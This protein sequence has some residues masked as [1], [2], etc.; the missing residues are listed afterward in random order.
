MTHRVG[1]KGQVVIPKAFRVALGL[2]AGDEVAFS[3]E[4]N[5]I[6]VERVVTV[7]ALMGRLARHRLVRALERDRRAERRR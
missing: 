5:A 7:D 2:E 3:R 1:R 4:G 6:R